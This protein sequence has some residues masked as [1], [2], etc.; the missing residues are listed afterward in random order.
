MGFLS[1]LLNPGNLLGG[2]GG[3][4]TS[5]SSGGIGNKESATTTH[6]STSTEY[7]NADNRVVADTGAIVGSSNSLTTNNYTTDAGAM[8]AGLDIAKWSAAGLDK[9]LTG[10]F[11]L[12]KSAQ[13]AMS[14]SI[15]NVLGIAGKVFDISKELAVSGQKASE[16]S[17]DA[18]GKAWQA[19]KDSSDGNR[20]LIVIGV[21]VAGLAAVKMFGKKGNA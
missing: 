10:A 21:I 20:S 13:A 14:T 12:S 6:T 4:N 16:Q 19:S 5:M 2:G 3:G 11:D 8:Q 17:R 1:G 15:E 7:N 9:G 18:V